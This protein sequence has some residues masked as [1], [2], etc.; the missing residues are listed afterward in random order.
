MRLTTPD[1]NDLDASLATEAVAID[2]QETPTLA[3]SLRDSRLADPGQQQPQFITCPLSGARVSADD[4]D[5]LAD[6]FLQLDSINKQIYGALSNIR[7]ALADQTEGTA[8]TRRLR[9]KRYR[10]KIEMPSDSWDS[11]ALRRAWDSFPQYRDEFLRIEKVGVQ[12]RQFKKIVN[13]VSSE[14]DFNQFRDAITGAN[15]GP[16]GTPRVTVE[17]E[18]E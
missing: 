11:G 8:K 14:E 7:R 1:K 4:I 9:S 17:T 5:G 12:L 6:L 3:G 15:N 16:T 18:A 13:E 10:L 2:S